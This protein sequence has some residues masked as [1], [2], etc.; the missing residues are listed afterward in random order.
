MT[1]AT[2]AEVQER[3]TQDPGIISTIKSFFAD[4]NLPTIFVTA[5]GRKVTCFLERRGLN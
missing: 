5:S 4:I 3:I 2:G 1:A